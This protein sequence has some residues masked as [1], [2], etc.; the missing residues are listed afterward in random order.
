MQ[1]QFLVSQEFIRREEL[2]EIVKQAVQ[3][4]LV[5]YQEK[6]SR[7]CKFNLRADDADRIR[8][9][10]R[11]ISD[12]GDGNFNVGIKQL[13][14]NTTLL[15]RYRRVTGNIGTVVITTILVGILTVL[16]SVFV[17]GIITWINGVSK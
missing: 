12:A 13:R 11:V 1:N 16:G 8:D 15:T 3:E 2:P 7:G 10:F 5:E 4:A 6:H 9:V 14:E 17:K